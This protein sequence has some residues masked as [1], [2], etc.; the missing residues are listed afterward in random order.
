MTEEYFSKNLE[1]SSQKILKKVKPQSRRLNK[2]R[3]RINC[4]I[5]SIW[6]FTKVEKIWWYLKD[7]KAFK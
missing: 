1:H 3:V 5:S 4:E 7:K 2:S 6:N